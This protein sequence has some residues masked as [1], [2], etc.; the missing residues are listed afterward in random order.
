MPFKLS[1]A[2]ALAGAALIGS[3]PA[4]A[5]G[6]KTYTDPAG[7]GGQGPDITL[8]VVANDDNGQITFSFTFSNRPTI[9]TGD[10]IVVLAIDADRRGN[11][12]DP[13]GYE[14]LLGF[15]FESGGAVEVGRWN[16]STYDFDVPQ[17][18][19]TARDGGRT[20]SINRAELG[21]TNAFDM[22]VITQGYDQNDTAPEGGGVWTYELQITV[23]APSI[24]G[25]RAAF[26][27]AQP[28]AG[29][30]FAVSR[31][32]L[33]LSDGSDVTP[34]AISC[35]GTIAGRTLR[36]SG[37]CRWIIPRNAR[38]KRISIVISASYAGGTATFQPYVF[39]IR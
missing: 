29:K 23:A 30:A 14:Y 26:S 2:L 25:V 37:R 33:R 19:L 6:S 15:L 10:D 27:P 20:I 24:A 9:L 38:G 32:L 13:S 3:A 39:R 31:T 28:R 36:T 18:T 11:T 16:G 7:D 1:I 5:A 34:A 21:G 17:T 22:R 12:G 4:Q 35:R 8:L